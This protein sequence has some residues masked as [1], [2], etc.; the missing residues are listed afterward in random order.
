MATKIFID[1]GHNPGDVN[2]GAEG[3]GYREQDI[4][5]AVG[6]YLRDILLEDGRFEARTSRNS[7]DEILGRPMSG[8]RTISSVSTAMP[9]KTRR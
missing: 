5:Y 4:T 8:V 1:Q 6:I 3:S 7:P 9:M 2:G